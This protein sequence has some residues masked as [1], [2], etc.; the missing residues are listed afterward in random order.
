MV[1]LVSK[2]VL[3]GPTMA[4]QVDLEQLRKYAEGIID[5]CIAGPVNEWLL[6]KRPCRP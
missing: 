4:N 5:G 3:M 1:Q 6:Q 2:A